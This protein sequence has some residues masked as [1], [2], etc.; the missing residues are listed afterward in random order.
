MPSH[1]IHLGIA[2]EV[3]KKLNR[4]TDL[5][6]LGSVL[7]DLTIEHDHGLSHF[8]YEDIYPKN[9]ANAEEFK[10]KYPN[11]KDDI[12]IGYII[13]LLTDKYYND[14]YYNTDL[15]W[16]VHNKEFNHNLFGSYDKYLLKHKIITKI[17]KKVINYIPNYKDITF[18]KEYLIKYIDELNKKIKSCNIDNS[19]HLE[20]Q[21]FL[22]KIYNDCIDYILKEIKKYI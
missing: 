20:H 16:I 9:L 19:F 10:K 4:N 15:D 21:I 6:K 12:S 2:Q 22:D 17:D 14:F 1:K 13:H 3:N 7:P 18:N 8:Q 11:M 5:I